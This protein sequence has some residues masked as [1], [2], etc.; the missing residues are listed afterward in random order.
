[1]LIPTVSISRW[2]LRLDHE[3]TEGL[4]ELGLQIYTSSA[5][6]RTHAASTSTR[7]NFTWNHVT[8]H[9]FYLFGSISKN[10]LTIATSR[11][12]RPRIV[13]V[14]PNSRRRQKRRNCRRCLK[15]RPPS[16]ARRLRDPDH[17][18]SRLKDSARRRRRPRRRKRYVISATPAQS[19][20]QLRPQIHNPRSKRAL[21]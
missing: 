13:A 18:S 5:H 20:S 12:S 11:V 19:P 17:P 6:S 10:V 21:C 2:R 9:R 4:A 15:R 1:M 8:P 7:H 14:N 3:G 16:P